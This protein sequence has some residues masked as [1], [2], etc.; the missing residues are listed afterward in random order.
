MK[1][2]QPVP[3]TRSA[4]RGPSD[5][6]PFDDLERIYL[7]CKD[8]ALEL[9][10]SSAQSPKIE[11]WVHTINDKLKDL[12]ETRTQWI[13]KA[14][15]CRQ[16]HHTLKSLTHAMIAGNREGWQLVREDNVETA[17][18]HRDTMNVQI[19][20]LRQ[21]CGSQ[22]AEYIEAQQSESKRGD[23]DD[24][25]IRSTLEDAYVRYMEAHTAWD[26]LTTEGEKA[27]KKQSKKKQSKK[28]QSKKESKKKEASLIAKITGVGTLF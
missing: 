20:R 10:S 21:L 22:M 23:N 15:R 27:K 6:V 17:T 12:R 7:N 3:N 5:R 1:K 14:G 11:S 16:P 18:I 24:D 25:A 9:G 13:A 28:K 2:E 19:R 26:A 4:K 8:V